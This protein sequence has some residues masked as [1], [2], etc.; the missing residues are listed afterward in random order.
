MEFM[1]KRLLISLTKL[2]N[3][4]DASV[5]PRT[6][7]EKFLKGPDTWVVNVPINVNSKFSKAVG[8]GWTLGAY[9]REAIAGA[10]PQVV[11]IQYP[12]Y[13]AVVMDHALKMIRKKSSAK[14]VLIVHDIESLRMSADHPEFLTAEIRRF[15]SV[16]GLIVHN[17]AMADWLSDHGVTV[18]M[19]Q[20]QLFDYVNP[21][22]VIT[23]SASSNICFAGNLRKA[24][25]LNDVPFKQVQVDVF[26]DGL[27]LT[28]AQLI[29]HGSKSPDELPKY[30]TD[31]FGLI[32][33]GNSADTCSGEYGEYLKYNSPHKASL[34]LSSGLPVI[35]WSQSALAPVVSSLGAGL[36]VGSLAEIEPVLSEL[37]NTEYLSMK[38]AALDTAKKLRSGQMI[39]TA[40]SSIEQKLQLNSRS[41]IV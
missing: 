31:R 26:G 4:H 30:L 33:D 19:S 10:N 34:Y 9:L 3:S 12:A 40:V 6:D 22:P 17:Q 1:V 13:S 36:V 23:D 38:R 15:N 21:Q 39:Q 24:Q 35:V 27:T 25:F 18:P 2:T 37:S 16:D 11:Y 14:I 8:V 7:I 29:D 32:W 20:L 28:N 41:G 5:K